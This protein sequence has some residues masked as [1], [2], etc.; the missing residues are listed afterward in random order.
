MKKKVAIVIVNYMFHVPN[1]AR[2]KTGMFATTNGDGNNGAFNL[3]INGIPMFAIASD[4]AGWEHCSV[5][6][7]KAN[8]TPTWEEMCAVKDVFWDK[9]DCVVQYHP[10]KDE[11]VNNHDFCLH[12]WRPMAKILVTP[13]SIL[14]G[15]K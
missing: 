13:P 2:I 1:E 11:Y 4:G 9:E 15:T 8:R 12:L 3:I 7:P 6:I 5:T 10:P 14:V